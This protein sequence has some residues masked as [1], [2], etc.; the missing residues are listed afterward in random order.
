MDFEIGKVVR[1]L[2]MHMTLPV[3]TMASMPGENPPDKDDNQAAECGFD[4]DGRQQIQDSLCP[5]RF[6]RNDGPLPNQP[7]GHDDA[8]SH[9]EQ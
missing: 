2:S 4:H 1:G 3:S 8:L 5:S 7:K 9:Q 6:H